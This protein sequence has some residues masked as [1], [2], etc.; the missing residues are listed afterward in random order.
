MTTVTGTA[1]GSREENGGARVI[2]A[3]TTTGDAERVPQNAYAWH[4]RNTHQHVACR[5]CRLVR[6]FRPCSITFSGVPEP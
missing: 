5:D 4:D 1:A 2:A 6:M 3:R